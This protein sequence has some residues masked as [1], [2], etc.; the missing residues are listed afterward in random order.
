MDGFVL[1]SLV[2]ELLE[3]RGGLLV[4]EVDA[5]GVREVEHAFAVCPGVGSGARAPETEE[6]DRGVLQ[7]ERGLVVDVSRVPAGDDLA[8]SRR[9]RSEK[10]PSSAVK[11]VPP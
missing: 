1:A 5:H 10:C 2:E 6:D 3:R 7:V 8:T 4:G 11:R 9:R